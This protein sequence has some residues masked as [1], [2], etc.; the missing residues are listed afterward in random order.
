MHALEHIER[1]VWALVSHFPGVKRTV[2]DCYQSTLDMF[3]AP[4]VQCDFPVTVR[5]GYYFGFHDKCP[6]SP[7][8]RILACQRALTPLRIPRPSD[9]V[10]IGVFEDHKWTAYRPLARSCA[11]NWQQGAMLQW[12]GD[13][14]HVIF[15]DFDGKNHIAR[16]IDARTGSALYRLPFPI[17]A[18]SGDGTVAVTYNFV[19]A[20]QCL[21]GYGYGHGSDSERDRLIPERHGIATAD[22]GSGKSH[23]LYTVA[24]LARIDPD[25]S[26]EGCFHWVTQCEFAKR[27]GRFTFLHRWGRPHRQHRTR[28]FSCNVD[29][30]ALHLFPTKHM[31][32]H[33]AWR[34]DTEVLAFARTARGTGYFLF[35]DRTSDYM[36][37]GNGVLSWDGHP[38]FTTNG[39]YFVTDTYPDRFR[40][41][42]IYVVDVTRD[43]IR[44]V[45]AFRAPKSVSTERAGDQLRVDLHPRWNRKGDTL[46][47]DSAHTGERSLCTVDV[48]PFGGT[49]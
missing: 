23:T 11:W 38:Q 5:I 42:R 43:E 19:R 31:V 2:R 15:N 4:A 41:Q 25:R 28:M 48:M 36:P 7:D 26:M 8:D 29:G 20:N 12:L 47:F 35:T 30:S 37:V 3:P 33:V 14:Y 18:V 1:S 45:G 34:N 13:S 9:E 24:D 6:F 40:R 46:C 27:G 21:P 10:E 44:C 39:Q 17:G 22:L 16:V 32:S 49:A